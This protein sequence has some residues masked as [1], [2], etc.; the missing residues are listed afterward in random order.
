M[1]QPVI[2]IRSFD[3]AG[4]AA[5]PELAERLQAHATVRLPPGVPGPLRYTG[6]ELIIALG[7]VGAFTAVYQIIKAYLER[8]RTAEV[9]ITYGD[10]HVSF[11]GYSAPDARTLIREVFPCGQE[12]L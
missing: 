4:R 8:H 12:E 7:S 2:T 9:S 10:K 3:E 6:A 11:K 1:T 5:Y